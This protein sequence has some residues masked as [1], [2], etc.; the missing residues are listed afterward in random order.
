MEWSLKRFLK[1]N[2]AGLDYTI[3]NSTTL[4]KVRNSKHF[5]PRYA[6]KSRLYARKGD[7]I[8]TNPQLNCANPKYTTRYDAAGTRRP[9][10]KAT[11]GAYQVK[12]H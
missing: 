1:G 9:A 4:F 6:N 12:K 7:Y 10:K 5:A 2:R 3:D 11:I 8:V